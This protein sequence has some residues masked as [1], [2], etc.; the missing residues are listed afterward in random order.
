MQMYNKNKMK[1][2]FQLK[3]KMLKLKMM[4]KNQKNLPLKNYDNFLNYILMNLVN[5]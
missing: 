1:K 5:E 2:R 4:K 3:M